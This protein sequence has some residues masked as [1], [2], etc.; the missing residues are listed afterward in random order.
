M[1]DDD[2]SDGGEVNSTAATREPK[3][4]YNSEDCP[5]D[6]DNDAAKHIFMENVVNYNS[7]FSESGCTDVATEIDSTSGEPAD[8]NKSKQPRTLSTEYNDASVCDDESNL[9]DAASF[10][11]TLDSI[12]HTCD[13]CG[14]VGELM[15]DVSEAIHDLVDLL[16]P[17]QQPIARRKKKKNETLARSKSIDSRFSNTRKLKSSY[18]RQSTVYRIDHDANI[19]QRRRLT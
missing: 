11:D 1:T 2:T 12:N 8:G 19:Q 5:V 17:K 16:K 4:G 14:V 13:P 3:E 9:N 7:F 6:D 18:R 15:A 10:D